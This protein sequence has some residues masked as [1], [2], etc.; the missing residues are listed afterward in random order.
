ML[1]ASK[2][3]G[4]AGLDTELMLNGPAQVAHLSAMGQWA[5]D[6]KFIYTG[7]RN[8]GGANFRAGE[9][10]LFTESSAGYAGISSEAEFNFEV[11]PLPY[12]KALT[13]EP[14][15]TISV[16]HLCGSWKAGAD[17]QRCWHF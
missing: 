2:D 17:E 6:G 11:R 1:P 16:V 9:C 3:N 13:D 14:Q 7:R 4:F 12:W 5:K 8:E 15:N 10:A